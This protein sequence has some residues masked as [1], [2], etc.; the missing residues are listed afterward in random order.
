MS[1]YL[2]FRTDR[3]GDFIFSRMITESIKTKNPSNKID[4][5]CSNY[6]SKYIK[7]YKDINKIFILDKYNFRL[8][9]KNLIEINSTKYD[10]LIILDGKRRSIFFSTF[11]KA[12][13]KLTLI[14]NWR[15]YFLLKIFFDNFLINSN[16]N[17]QYNNFITLANLID[18]KVPKKIDYYKSYLFKKNNKIVIKNNFV[19]L[20]LDEKWFK[21]FYYGDFDF[22]DL[23]C[24][25]FKFLI[26]TIFK[27]FKKSIIITNGC[28]KVPIFYKIIN[29]YFKKIDS[30]K[31]ESINFG[32]KLIFI[33]NTKFQD[34]EL[35]VKNSS[36]VF[37]CEG[38]ITHVSHAMQKKTYALI[39]SFETGKFWT[40]HMPK[41][42]LLKR[43]PIKKI[44]GD[45]KKL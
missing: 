27:R 19:L 33:D 16:V 5:V 44:C 42:K 34:L 15:P 3:I 23:D 35:F 18:L 21:G 28:I 43:G 41:I 29:K 36:I 1:K 10:Y 7:N 37:C 17:S 22:M 8:M 30:N 6:N 13:Y 39:N 32:R 25:N 31:F 45:L 12:K 38:A 4:F 40:S 24:E 14:N 26:N 9:L 20:H 11:I 2:I